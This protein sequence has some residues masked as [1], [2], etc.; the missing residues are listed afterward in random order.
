MF[1]SCLYKLA[2]RSETTR[3][4][5]CK[6][7]AQTVLFSVILGW[8]PPPFPSSWSSSANELQPKACAADT[9]LFQVEHSIYHRGKRGRGRERYREI[10]REKER[11]RERGR[12]TDRGHTVTE[13]QRNSS[14]TDSIFQESHGLVCTATCLALVVKPEKGESGG[15][16]T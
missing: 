9:T 10:E 2:S 12:E 7:L 14:R 3:K 6:M 8:I 5:L 11:E 13:P 4:S 15:P 1:R 16:S